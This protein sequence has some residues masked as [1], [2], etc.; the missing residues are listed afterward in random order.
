MF[1]GD[2]CMAI[3]GQCPMSL[4]PLN[5]PLTE[6]AVKLTLK[7]KR[8]RNQITNCHQ[9]TPISHLWL[10]SGQSVMGRK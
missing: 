3:G 4:R 9:L 10:F 2:K 5:T 1:T 8:H 6:I 7:V